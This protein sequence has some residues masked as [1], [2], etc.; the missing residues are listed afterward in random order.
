MA[1]FIQLTGL[2]DVPSGLKRCVLAIGN[3]DG[4]HRGHQH[5]F[6]RLK[7]R[8]A[9]R[10]VAAVVLTFE[11]HPRDVFSPA[12]VMFRLTPP[13]AKARLAQALGLDALV[14]M[15]FDRAFSQ[16]PAEDFVSRFLIGALDVSRV[17]V[18][19]DFHFG[20]NRLGTP[21]YL[22]EAG[23]DQGFAVET[24]HL[25]DAG[26]GPISSSRIREALR[27]GDLAGAIALLGYHWFIEGEVVSGARRGRELGYPTANLAVPPVFDLARGVYAVRGLIDGKR[28]D[29]VAAYGKPMFGDAAPPFETFFFDFAEDIYGRDLSVALLGRIR[30]ME[31]FPGL[32][33]LIEAMDRDS[34]EAR[35]IITAAAPLGELDHRLGFFG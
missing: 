25:I 3:F 23:R 1:E 30:G 19:D 6:D 13:E 28:L 18:G 17:I 16:I 35:R 7:A 21:D 26:E 31:V 22:R 15:P 33:E 34:Q 12:P 2:D 9:E 8:A 24:L 27:R 20:R 10:G 4:F 11:P 29:G 32:P 5:V 14:V